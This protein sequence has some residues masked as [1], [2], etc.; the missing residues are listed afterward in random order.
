MLGCIRSR[1]YVE[2][3]SPEVPLLDKYKKIHVDWL[4]LKEQDWQVYRFSS[5]EEWRGVIRE[6]NIDGF[7]K[8]IK[9]LLPRK[10]FSFATSNS[11]EPGKDMELHIKFSDYSITNNRP[12]PFRPGS[13][14]LPIKIHFIDLRANKEIYTGS[15]TA[16]GYNK[17]GVNFEDRLN[18]AIYDLALFIAKKLK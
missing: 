7:H 14:E 18:N 9:E 16:Y 6:M 12:A 13:I 11:D 2:N 1:A 4:D 10:E 15:I 17:W 8:Y 5:M 3:E